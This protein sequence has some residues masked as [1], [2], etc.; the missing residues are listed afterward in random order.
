MFS[1]SDAGKKM[2]LAWR[3][4]PDRRIFTHW[5]RLSLEVLESYDHD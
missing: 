2:S 5:A 1:S 4:D 3:D